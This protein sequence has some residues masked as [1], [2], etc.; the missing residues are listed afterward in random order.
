MARLQRSCHRLIWLNPLL[1]SPDYQPLT[2]GMQAAL[3]YVDDFLPAHNL[4]SLHELA[5]HLN[6][7]TLNPSPVQRPPARAWRQP[8]ATTGSERESKPDTNGAPDADAAAPRPASA[9]HSRRELNPALA[10]TFRHPLWGH[11]NL[12]GGGTPNQDGAG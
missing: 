6:Q 2:R 3:P 4:H 8:G 9:A 1:G 11:P 12:P 7:L 10:P 5:R